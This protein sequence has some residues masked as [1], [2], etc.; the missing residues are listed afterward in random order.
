MTHK[1]ITRRVLTVGTMLFVLVG[2]V[3]N[4]QQ[5]KDTVK[6]PGGPA[7]SEFRGYEDWQ[8]VAPSETDSQYVIRL[9]L[10]YPAMIKAYREGVPGNGN[11]SGRF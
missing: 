4:A 2:V 1:K 10:A 5:N 9:I 11:L 7:L 6:G 8:A 3:L